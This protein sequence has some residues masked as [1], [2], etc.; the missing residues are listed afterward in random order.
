MRC[1]VLR[2]V[3]VRNSGRRDDDEISAVNHWRQMRT[4]HE[5]RR[6]SLCPVLYDLDSAALGNRP[7]G[8][9]RTGKKPDFITA[10]GEVR[11]HRTTAIAGAQ[12]SHFFYRHEVNSPVAR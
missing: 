7:Q 6:K 8:A 3:F 11:R 9:L 4:H 1:Q 5:W 12:D 2:Q 10:K